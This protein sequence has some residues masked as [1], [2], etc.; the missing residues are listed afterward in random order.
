M[1]KVQKHKEELHDWPGH[2]LY[3]FE[4]ISKGK[5]W[6][7]QHQTTELA[8]IFIPSFVTN[9]NILLMSLT[10]LSKSKNLSLVPVIWYS[11]GNTGTSSFL[12][13]FGKICP[14]LISLAT[15]VMSKLLRFGRFT[16]AVGVKLVK[17]VPRICWVV[18]SV[19]DA[20]LLMLALTLLAHI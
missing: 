9:M 20:F 2:K 14:L 12:G 3:I 13:E 18:W 5:V 10:V 6:R 11:W 8:S 19:V 16:T 7:Y 4:K 1:A 17:S 15:N